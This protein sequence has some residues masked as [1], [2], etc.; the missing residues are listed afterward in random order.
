MPR[1]VS[2]CALPYKGSLQTNAESY[3]GLSPFIVKAKILFGF[4]SVS[5]N[6]HECRSSVKQ[7]G[8]KRTVD[9]G[10]NG[11]STFLSYCEASGKDPEG[12]SY[13]L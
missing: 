10:G 3:F 9:S 6:R 4:F 5:E 12:E 13:S 11:H 1:L 7:S 2:D 8:V